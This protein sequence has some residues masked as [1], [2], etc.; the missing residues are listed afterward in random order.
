MILKKKIHSSLDLTIKYVFV[1]ENNYTLEFSYINKN[2]G[3]DIICVPSQT[4]CNMACKFCHCT[5]YIGKIKSENLS[6]K[7]L[8]YGIEYITNDL[9]LSEDKMLL[10]SFMGIGEPIL[11]VENVLA[12]MNFFYEKRNKKYIRFAFATCIPKNNW[13]EFFKFTDSIKRFKLPVKLHLSLHY[14]N[15]NIREQWMPGS[16]EIFQSLAAIEFYQKVTGNSVE[17]HYALIDGLNDSEEDAIL[18]TSFIKNKFI[19]VKFLFFNE[20]ESID[21]HRSNENKLEIFR[22]YFDANNIHFEYYIPPGLD[23]GA[24]CGMFLMDNYINTK[25]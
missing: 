23:I 7:D 5:D 18:L 10:I 22:K 3:K 17:I 11:N 12:T 25:Q 13:I 1:N 6:K 24:S 9:S 14:T 15:D 21:Y 20:K 4:M 2:D 19:D 16:L 8:I